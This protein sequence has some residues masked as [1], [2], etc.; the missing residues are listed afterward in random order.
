MDTAAVRPLM[1]TLSRPGLTPAQPEL[2]NARTVLVIE[3]DEDTRQFV[4]DLLT[5]EGYAVLG[6]A[7]G[8]AAREQ[9]AAH[10]IGVT[11]LDRR[12]PDAH[13]V[14]LCRWLRD[15]IDGGAPIILVTAD[16]SPGLEA[17]AVPPALLISCSSRIF[18]PICSVG[19]PAQPEEPF[20]R[21]CRIPP[22]TRHGRPAQLPATTRRHARPAWRGN[23]TRKRLPAPSRLSTVIHPSWRRRISCATYRPI[24]NPLLCGLTLPAR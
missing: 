2:P 11:L 8:Q 15:H 22:G 23:M 3:D 17:A 18:P 21:P 12:L 10:A 5:M 9:V 13:G 1:G 4:E 19:F 14:E 6:A 24:P 7:T 20:R 16:R